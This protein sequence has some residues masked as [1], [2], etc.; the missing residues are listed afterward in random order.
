[1]HISKVL[2]LRLRQ[3]VLLEKG[4][5]LSR[6]QVKECVRRAGTKLGHRMH[7]QLMGRKKQA[8]WYTA[9]T[10][11]QPLA[12]SQ[13]QP[14][15]D[16]VV[17][18][19][20]MLGYLTREE[21][22]DGFQGQE[23]GHCGRHDRQPLVHYLL[24]CLVTDAL[25]AAQSPSAQPDSGGLLTRPRHSAMAKCLLFSHHWQTDARIVWQ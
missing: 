7:Q 10:A 16:G 22:Y 6:R 2:G 14:W 17:L 12:A 11:Y 18:Q 24:S 1:M 25:R 3:N 9:A 8:A 19:R 13:Q 15:A 4:I 23:C 21:L 5:P 20:V